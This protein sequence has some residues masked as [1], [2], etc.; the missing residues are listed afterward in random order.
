MA[1]YPVTTT[2]PQPSLS[3]APTQQATT[4]RQSWPVR[5]AIGLVTAIVLLG[6]SALLQIPKP[7]L[8][9]TP[10]VAVP[11]HVGAPVG[12]TATWAAIKTTTWR[13][14]K[15]LDAVPEANPNELTLYQEA[16]DLSFPKTQMMSAQITCGIC[17]TQAVKSFRRLSYEKGV[18]VVDCPGC[19]NRHVIADNLGWGLMQGPEKN[20]EELF[21]QQGKKVLYGSMVNGTVHLLN[22]IRL[23][24]DPRQSPGS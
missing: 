4:H 1:L 2:A 6:L 14:P 19:G 11:H 5:A 12:W 8:L 22:E 20:I 21:A 3:A 13:G 23:A 9:F 15:K 16:S 24:E 17:G 18:V 7:V 10:R